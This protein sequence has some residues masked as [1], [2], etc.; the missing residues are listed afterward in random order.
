MENRKTKGVADAPD[1]CAAIL[2]Y[3][4]RL[5]NWAGRNLMKFMRKC[6]VLNLGRNNPRHQHTLGAKQLESS[7]VKEALGVP[8]NNKFN[9]KSA[10]RTCSQDHQQYPALH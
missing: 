5:E 1:G 6:R 7:F 9:C 10:M 4:D 2:H 3:F 8:T